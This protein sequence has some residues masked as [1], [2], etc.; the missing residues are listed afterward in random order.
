[1]SDLFRELLFWPKISKASLGFLGTVHADGLL[2]KFHSSLK[3]AESL[4][5]TSSGWQLQSALSNVKIIFNIVSEES[6]QVTEMR[7]LCYFTYTV[8]SSHVR[9]PHFDLDGIFKNSYPAVYSKLLLTIKS[10]KGI[11]SRAF[12]FG[13]TMHCEVLIIWGR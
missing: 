6:K 3:S 5:S 11:Y 12:S 1:M 8:C 7:S 10:R 4:A 13:I 9:V 2:R